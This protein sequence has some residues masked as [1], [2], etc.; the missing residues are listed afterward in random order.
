[1]QVQKV[2]SAPAT[3]TTD[4]KFLF[5]ASAS[6]HAEDDVHH[7]QMYSLCIVLSLDA[8]VIEKP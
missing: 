6:C 7:L 3:R 4:T 5:I 1:M 2:R 8:G